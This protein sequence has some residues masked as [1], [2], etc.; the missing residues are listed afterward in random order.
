MSTYCRETTDAGP[1]PLLGG[2]PDR[3]RRLRALLARDG[4]LR[5]LDRSLLLASL[6]LTA[7]GTV[8][9]FSATRSRDHLTGGD[10]Y[11]FLLR[12]CLNILI[13]LLLAA[14][15][16]RVGHRRL[17]DAAPVL[18][19]LSV[20]LTALV[21][22]PL[23]STVN[24]ARRWIEIGGGFAFQPSELV[25]VAVILA[26]AALVASRAEAAS[27][28]R[29]GEQHPP[30]ALTV[31]ALL[32]LVGLPA[33]LVLLTPD[34]GQTLGLIAI[35][36]ALLTAAGAHR[37]WILGLIG[38]GVAGAVAVWQLGVLD[39]YQINRVAAFANPEL[40]PAGVGYNTHQ[41][42]IAIGAGG[43]TGM[44][45]FQGSQT[46]G[47]FVPEQHTDFIFTVAGEELGFVGGATIILLLGV[48]MWRALRIARDCPDLYGTVLAAGIAGWLAFQT[49]ENIGM[50]L[51]IMPVTGL[52]LPFVSYGGSSMFAVWIAVGLLQAIHLQTTA[53]R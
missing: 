12:H 1:P 28:R 47:Q 36:L 44:G 4:P 37:V 11:H 45:L 35:V 14:F 19:G 41:A 24:G 6:A 23:G 25:K 29:P 2:R 52:P 10:P 13:G 21:L 26:A 40:D 16:V 50:S 34:L 8:L 18:Y 9:V 7:L 30:D 17:R 27:R 42:R 31:M 5:R 39:E 43:L 48:V 33:V 46:V 38:A 32:L 49:F 53:R 3:P 22:T 20:V 51:G 15:V